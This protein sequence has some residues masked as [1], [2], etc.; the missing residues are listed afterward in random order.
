MQGQCQGVR[1]TK[2]TESTLAKDDKDLNAPPH[3]S[4]RD[5]LITV[6]NLRITMY[7]DH[8]GKFPHIS[9]LGNQYIMILHNMNSNSLWAE[10]IKNN[11]EGKLI[12]ARQHALA[13]MKR[14]G[15]VPMHQILNNQAS[16]A[17]KIAIETSKMTYQL[18]PPDNHRQNMAEKAIQTFK[19][20][21]ISVLSGCA[22]TMLMHLWGQLL[23]QVEL[24]L[25]L[26]RQSQVNP[27]MSAYAHLYGQHNY[28]KHPFV[29]IGMEALVHDK[30]HRQR[31][32]A[33]H[34]RKTFVLSTSTKHYQCWK[35]WSNNTWAAHVLGAEFFKH[36]YI[37][38]PAVTLEDLVIAAAANLSKALATNMPHHL[39]QSSIQALADLQDVFSH[40]ANK[41]D[42]DPT[43]HHI[44]KANIPTAPRRQ[45]LDNNRLQSP[46]RTPAMPPKVQPSASLSRVPNDVIQSRRFSPRMHDAPSPPVTPT[47][48]NFER[49]IFPEQIPPENLL[50]SKK[51]WRLQRIAD[52]NILNRK[53]KTLAS[54]APTRNRRS[55][56]QVQTIT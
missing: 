7:T 29:Q 12:L 17:Y 10:A 13:G 52:I 41:Y 34:C 9:S 20:H 24:Q 48:L 16:A 30:P 39:R 23:P 36:K 2:R 53:P 56:T 50:S 19:N 45:Q 31:T 28:N 49:S 55:Q 18:V 8:T 37:T 32:Y 25:L 46:S 21:F 35:F 44:P 43:T 14:C 22:P 38:N 40:A 54:D 15:I 4:K 26:L 33:E 11:T 1:S 6:Y 47:R 27:N 51:L 5:V 42:D 3:N